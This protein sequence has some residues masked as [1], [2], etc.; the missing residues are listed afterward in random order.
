MV[1]PLFLEG[2]A[3]PL[4]VLHALVAIPLAGAATHLLLVCWKILRGK[5]PAPR[6]A[7]LYARVVGILFV[8]DFG[9]GLLV[10]PTYRV[11]VRGLY[12]DHVAPWAAN[13]FDLKEILFGLGLPMAAALTFLAGRWDGSREH[14]LTPTLSGIT[15]TLWLMLAFGIVSGLWVT[16]V[17]G[18]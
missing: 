18:V 6:L 10:Y 16:A 17:K 1:P 3:R 8:I 14:E 7:R 2:A 9:L 4:L 13:L 5:R 12:F 11:R 15:A